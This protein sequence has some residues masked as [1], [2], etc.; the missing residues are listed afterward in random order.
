MRGVASMQNIRRLVLDVQRILLE[1]NH[2]LLQDDD[3]ESF[4]LPVASSS[5][6]DV[7]FSA[8]FVGSDSD[9]SIE[10]YPTPPTQKPQKP[11]FESAWNLS[12]PNTLGKRKRV[13]PSTTERV[14][15]NP[16]K[17]HFSSTLGLDK[18]GRSVKGV[19]KPGNRRKYNF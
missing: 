15:L 6:F 17:E 13:G 2:I 9:P 19:L 18:N 4:E 5:D 14:S 1:A 11:R 16:V 12:N 7:D 3:P 10:P 8:S